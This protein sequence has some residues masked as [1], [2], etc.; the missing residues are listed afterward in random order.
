MLNAGLIYEVLS[1][2]EEIPEDLAVEDR[3]SRYDSRL[4]R[5]KYWKE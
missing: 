2:A 1:V 3:R 5:L 4:S